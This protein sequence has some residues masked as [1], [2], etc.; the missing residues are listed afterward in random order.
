MTD[1]RP[2]PLSLNRR[3]G[4]VGLFLAAG[5]TGIYAV[6]HSNPTAPADQVATQTGTIARGESA[7][8]VDA[9]SEAMQTANP[10]LNTESVPTP[11]MMPASANS[12]EVVFIVRI[13]GAPEIDTIARNFKR[14]RE[15]AEAAFADLVTAHPALA[16]FELVG[17]SYSGE[18]KLSFTLPPGVSPTRDVVM[19]IKQKIMAIEGVAY[20][21]PDYIA[22]PDKEN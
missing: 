16:E 22:H 10:V 3:I 15:T 1:F 14:N 7:R 8:P 6:S 13:K 17:A 12:A 9:A 18:I 21:D 2:P 4:L 19:D 20:A 11:A 5:A